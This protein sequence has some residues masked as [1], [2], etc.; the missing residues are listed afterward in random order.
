MLDGAS[1]SFA[2]MRSSNEI[3]S[4]LDAEIKHIIEAIV[5]DTVKFKLVSC[6]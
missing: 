1:K 2:E 4:S 6:G 5:T 3:L